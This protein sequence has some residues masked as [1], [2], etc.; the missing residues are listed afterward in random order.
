MEIA[1]AER[2]RAAT[3]GEGKFNRKEAQ[4]VRAA[5]EKMERSPSYISPVGDCVAIRKFEGQ[6]KTTTIFTSK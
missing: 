1:I 4:S 3:E 5:T 2:A 6:W